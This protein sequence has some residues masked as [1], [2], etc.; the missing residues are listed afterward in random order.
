M[1]IIDEEKTIAL[2]KNAIGDYYGIEL[3]VEGLNF[4]AIITTGHFT[5]T[6]KNQF[7]NLLQKMKY[8]D[9]ELYSMY[10]NNNNTLK[11]KFELVKFY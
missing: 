5:I 7:E 2:I 1:K 4:Y 9:F 10:S 6:T 8:L 3:M 11:F